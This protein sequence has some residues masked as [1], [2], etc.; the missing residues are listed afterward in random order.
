M[1]RWQCL[2]CNK[3]GDLEPLPQKC[4][5]C[6]QDLMVECID[7]DYDTHDDDPKG[8]ATP[9]RESPNDKKAAQSPNPKPP[10]QRTLFDPEEP[11]F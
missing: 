10:R 6:H 7:F 2:R 3:V 8:H 5:F 11:E 9:V 1:E 4:P